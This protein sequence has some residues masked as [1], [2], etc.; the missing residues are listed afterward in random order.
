MRALIDVRMVLQWKRSH[1][2]DTELQ[3]LGLALATE[4]MV[5]FFSKIKLNF[6]NEET[7]LVP[8]PSG[9]APESSTLLGVKVFLELQKLGLALATEIMVIFFSKIKLNFQNEETRLVPVPSGAAPG[10]PDSPRDSAVVSCRNPP[11][12]RWIRFQTDCTDRCCHRQPPHCPTTPS[13]THTKGSHIPRVS[14]IQFRFFLC[15]SKSI[16]AWRNSIISF[17]GFSPTKPLAQNLKGHFFDRNTKFPCIVFR[18]F[19]G[20]GSIVC[21]PLLGKINIHILCS[22]YGVA[23]LITFSDRINESLGRIQTDAKVNCMRSRWVLRVHLYQAK[24]NIFVVFYMNSM[25]NFLQ[26]YLSVNET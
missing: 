9:A 1:L 19:A 2:F 23:N 11:S 5:F 13:T 6:Q 17:L 24:A 7:R 22:P 25:L 3:K 20:F 16:A 10:R 14:S 12:H 4:I 21:F 15:L 18:V 8:V 26:T